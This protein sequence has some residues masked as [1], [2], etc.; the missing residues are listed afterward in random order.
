ML[1]TLYC[2]KQYNVL[3]QCLKHYKENRPYC[4][5][6]GKYSIDKVT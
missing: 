5:T 3:K 2:Y 6:D 4:Y 1:L